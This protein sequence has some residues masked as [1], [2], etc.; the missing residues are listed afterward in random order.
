MS[1]PG[2][3][4]VALLSDMTP[5]LR[6]LDLSVVDRS[7]RPHLQPWVDQGRLTQSLR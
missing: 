1:Y 4:Q 7:S 6:R 3:C 2:P 5:G